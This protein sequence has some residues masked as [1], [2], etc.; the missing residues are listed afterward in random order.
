MRIC[1]ITRGFTPPLK[2]LMNAQVQELAKNLA[3]LGH[4][5]EIISPLN[6]DKPYAIHGVYVPRKDVLSQALNEVLFGF[7][8]SINV[9]KLLNQKIVDIIHYYSPLPAFLSKFYNNTNQN[10]HIPSFFECGTPVPK[11]ARYSTN[12][13]Q[14]LFNKISLALHSQAMK[15][16]D[17]IIVNSN[18]LKSILYKYFNINQSKMEVVPVGVN[19]SLC[20]PH[21]EHIKLKRECNLNED[22]IIDVA[23][24]LPLKNQLSLIKCI[25]SIIKEHPNAKFIF[26]GPILSYKYYVKI[27]KFIH[28]HNLMEK[29]IFTGEVTHKQVMQYYAI[30]DVVVFPSVVEGCPRALL[31]AMSCSKPSVV[32][33]MGF[34]KELAKKGNEFVFVK[35]FDN[36][37]MSN[38]IINLLSDYETSK[39]LGQRARNTVLQYFDW[40][41][42][43]TEVIKL[44]ESII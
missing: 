25:P 14:F 40:K 7:T 43:A 17:K 20:I 22:I 6:L 27:Q 1:F 10:M 2:S 13:S 15:E 44:Y 11:V 39:M 34:N 26:I 4:T 42:V 21:K 35:P 9:K 23:A 30:A 28:S 24:I 41:I 36:E 8:S 33:S 18:Y 29:I 5:V 32:Y 31:E 19:P 16:V 3:I 38:A 12:T 37:D